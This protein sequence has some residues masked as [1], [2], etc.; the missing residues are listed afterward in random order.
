MEYHDMFEMVT[1]PLRI[2]DR[3]M[4]RSISLNKLK[5]EFQVE[6]KLYHLGFLSELMDLALLFEEKNQ[7]LRKGG[8]AGPEKG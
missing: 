2:G 6:L 4:L 7:A 3:R 1:A 8:V 5:K